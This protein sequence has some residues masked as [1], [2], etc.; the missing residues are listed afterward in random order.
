MANLVQWSAPSAF[1]TLIAGGA[2]AP[3]LKNLANNGQKLGDAIDNNRARFADFDLLFRGA[4]APS[5]GGY[6][7]LYLVPRIDGTNFAD[8]DDT[9][10]PGASLHL[11]DFPSRAVTTAQRSAVQRV[12]IPPGDWKPLLVNKLGVALTN[13]D[14][15]NV[16]SYVT[17]GEE[18][19]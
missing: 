6:C 3:T 11:C 5:A 13:T 7:A 4:T 10:A 18:I 2:S 8:G 14:N 15:E 12:P 19:Q 17:Y 16:L 1:T 9:V